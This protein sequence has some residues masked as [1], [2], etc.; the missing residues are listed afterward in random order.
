[1]LIALAV[2]CAPADT[3]PPSQ[4][5]SEQESAVAFFA[6][7]SLAGLLVLAADTLRF[8]AC[9]TASPGTAVRDETGEARTL[10]QQFGAATSGISVLVRTDAARIVEIRYAGLEGPDCSHLPPEGDLQARGNEPFWSVRIDGA[11][12]IVR[13]PDETDGIRYTGGSWT[14]PHDGAWTYQATAEDASGGIVIEIE[15]A[16]CADSMSGAQYPYRA[17]LVRNGRRM[18]GCALEGLS[19]VR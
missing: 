8:I 5:S 12:A 6:G 14:Q 3:G 15:E 13:T 16:R 18:Q 17:L 7:P 4:A 11:T 19:A 10:L 2:C 1:M 9:G